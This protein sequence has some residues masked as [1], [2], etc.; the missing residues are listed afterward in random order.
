MNY[1]NKN[2]IM[3]GYLFICYVLHIHCLLQSACC[4]LIS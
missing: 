4:L 2:L 1:S 3:E